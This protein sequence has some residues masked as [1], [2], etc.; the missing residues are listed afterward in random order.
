M[1]NPTSKLKPD[2]IYK[3]ISRN[4]ERNSLTQILDFV[5]R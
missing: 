4:Y 2:A 5:L 3:Y 1:Q